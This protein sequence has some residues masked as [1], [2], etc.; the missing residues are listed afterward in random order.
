MANYSKLNQPPASKHGEYRKPSRRKKT[1]IGALLT[2]LVVIMAVIFVMSIFFRVTD[3]QVEGNEHYTDQEIIKAVVIEEGDNLFFFDRIAA[4]SRVFAKLPYI[5]E[6]SV[7]RQLPNKVIVS[8]QECK[9]LAYL[10]VGDEEWAIDH[11]CKI[12]GKA[13]AEETGD[14]IP[15]LGVSPG[16]LMIGEK[17]TT[18]DGNEELVDFISQVLYQL[19]ERGLASQ[20]NKIDFSNAYSVRIAFGDGRYTF[21]IGGSSN[22][23]YKFGMIVSVMSQLKAGDVGTIDVSDGT[24]A[25]FIPN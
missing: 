10:Q 11:S 1:G 18:A 6:V 13:T 20:V 4:T 8:V 24:T 22:V 2:F 21:K 7:E 9:A 23:E 5:E 25:H 17:L 19:Q 15:I 16:T 3:I 14:L 12:L